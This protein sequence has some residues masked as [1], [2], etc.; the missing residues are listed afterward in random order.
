MAVTLETTIKKYR[1]LSTDP[2]PGT[3]GLDEAIPA[4]SVFIE[5]DTNQQYVW[6]GRWPWVLQ[7]QS[8]GFWLE[9]LSL[10]LEGIARVLL[11]THNG[12]VE[13]EIIESDEI[14]DLN[15]EEE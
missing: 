12:M 15:T 4:G 2:K 14:N 7:A 11:A 9:R 5:S 10:Q 8:D 6:T 1:G 3:M 13:A